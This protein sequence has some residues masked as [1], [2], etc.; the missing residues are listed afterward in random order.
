MSERNVPVLIVGGGGA[1]LTC[2]MLLSQLGIDTWLVNARPSTSDLPKAH[3]LNQRA[4]EILK[5][6]G[7]AETIYERGTPLENMKA[8]AWYA[9]LAGDDEDFGRKL[10]QLEAWGAGYTNPDWVAA[11]PC[12]STNLPQIRL[13]PLLRARAEEM[14]PGKVNFNHEV[15]DIRQDAEGV[16]TTIRD[17]N[18]NNAYTVKSKYVLACDGG[19]T[20]GPALG[21]EMEGPRD[22]SEQITIHMTADLSQWARDPDVLIRW[23]WPPQVGVMSVLVPMGPEKWGPESEEW[24]FHL[25]YPTDDPRALDN[26]KIEKDMRAALGIS[27]HP[28]KIH[29]ITRWSLEGVVAERL[30]V[31]RV[32]LLGDAAHRHPP[33]GGL[34]LNSAI[35]DAHNMC[36]KLAAVLHGRASGALLESYA[37]ERKPVVQNNVDCSVESALNHFAIAEAIGI[38]PEAGAEQNW[39]SVKRLWND[40]PEDEEFRRLVAQ[41]IHTQT[42]EF[43]EHNIEYGYTYRREGAAIVPGADEVQASPDSRRLYQPSTVP[44][45][46]LPHAWVDTYEGERVST[47]DLVQPGRFLLIAGEN[48]PAWCDAAKQ[49]A[50]GLDL[51]LDA[52]IIGASNGDY[53]DQ[54]SSW[55]AQRGITNE[56]AILVRPDRFVAWRNL[57]SSAAPQAELERALTLVLGR[58]EMRNAA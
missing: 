3:V 14:A 58:D 30:Q 52:V 42:M 31:G 4:M 44:G 56:G 48:G 53:L 47:L 18:N 34:G 43:G 23:M 2:S 40:R 10:G 17:L 19:R 57:G 29:K 45:S 38:S 13:E 9:G 35:Q 7:L 15:I 20:I 16:T 1:G 22:L 21:V 5:D 8:S 26:D 28:V 11:S 46:C 49:I 6:V 37:S 36:W 24:V 50:K 54:R 12:A 27:D 25:N 39:K 32:F 41:S 33:T 55:L 51:P